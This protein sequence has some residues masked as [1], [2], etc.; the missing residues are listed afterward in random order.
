MV[1]TNNCSKDQSNDD[2]GVLMNFVGLCSLVNDDDGEGANGVLLG[3]FEL[4]HGAARHAGERIIRYWGVGTG[5]V[6]EDVK[7]KILD[8]RIKDMS[9]DLALDITNTREI[10][11]FPV[12][13]AKKKRFMAL[14]GGEVIASNNYCSLVICH[15][16]MLCLAH[17]IG[18]GRNWDKLGGLVA[19]N[20]VV[21]E[22]VFGVDIVKWMSWVCY[23]NSNNCGGV[24][25]CSYNGR[26]VGGICIVSSGGGGGSNS[27]DDLRE[28][29]KGAMLVVM[30]MVVLA[31]QGRQ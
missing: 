25:G 12:E 28:T 6:V 16:V 8:G 10:F 2:G 3:L 21:L 27:R 15:S 29:V 17:G 31:G 14:D 30:V 1:M 24:S 19:T 23:D 20:V 22:V 11:N 13:Y 7:D 9:D 4:H 26:I 5:W 18:V